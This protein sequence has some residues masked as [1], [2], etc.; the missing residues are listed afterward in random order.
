M[1]VH[2]VA[3]GDSISRKQSG[4]FVKYNNDLSPCLF[5]HGG[6]FSPFS[7]LH[8]RPLLLLGLL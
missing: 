7:S 3:K 5:A 4:A 6:L 8:I 2:V 1:V